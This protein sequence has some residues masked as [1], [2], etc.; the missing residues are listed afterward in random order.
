MSYLLGHI[1]SNRR[2]RA[3]DSLPVRGTRP[4]PGTVCHRLQMVK[5]PPQ[6]ILWRIVKF[7]WRPF[8]RLF[9]P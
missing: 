7:H 3:A 2:F 9:A 6:I 1:A 4:A 5:A 8:K